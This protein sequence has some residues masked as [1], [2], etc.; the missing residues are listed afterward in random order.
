MEPQSQTTVPMPA[1]PPFNPCVSSPPLPHYQP[2]TPGQTEEMSA[3]ASYT[4]IPSV[5]GM[6]KC[7]ATHYIQGYSLP[8]QTATFP[9]QTTQYIIQQQ[10]PASGQS[11][12]PPQTAYYTLPHPSSSTPPPLLTQPP[13]SHHSSVASTQPPNPNCV[14]QQA[15]AASP[16]QAPVSSQMFSV[17]QSPPA[18]ATL[19]YPAMTPHQV[20]ATKSWPPGL[21]GN[22]GY[23]P[24]S[25]PAQQMTIGYVAPPPTHSPAG[26]QFV[27]LHPTGA[28]HQRPIGPT[29]IQFGGHS[30]GQQFMYRPITP[31]RGKEQF[32][33]SNIC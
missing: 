9:A 27:A 20:L 19:A 33:F 8:H 13:P 2:L 29:V 28:P 22:P 3:A 14:T 16:H 18:G 25:P 32:Y 6:V 23:R 11:Y 30:P 7:G 12:G 17:V 1:L 24:S 31:L 10:Q 26:H 21:L 5:D 4:Q 15:V